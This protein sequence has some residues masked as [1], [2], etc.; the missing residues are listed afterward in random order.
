MKKNLIR[1][2][3]KTFVRD[4][5]FINYKNNKR[6]KNNNWIMLLGRANLIEIKIKSY[7]GYR[8]IIRIIRG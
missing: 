1:G 3:E 4:G 5:H 6:S 7:L 2:R 8:F